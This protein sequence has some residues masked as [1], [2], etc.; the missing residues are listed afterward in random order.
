MVPRKF[1]SSSLVFPYKNVSM[2]NVNDDDDRH[3]SMTVYYGNIIFV[4]RALNRKFFT[5]IR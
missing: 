1:I 4:L 2:S 3:N 5:F